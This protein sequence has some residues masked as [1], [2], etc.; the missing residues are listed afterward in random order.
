M[1]K[2]LVFSLLLLAVGSSKAQEVIDMDTDVLFRKNHSDWI[3]TP[4]DSGFAILTSADTAD[5]FS[6]SAFPTYKGGGDIYVIAR[7]AKMLGD[8]VNAKLQLGLY[9]GEGVSR[10]DGLTGYEWID[11]GTF[12]AVGEQEFVLKDLTAVSDK[13]FSKYMFRWIETGDQKNDYVQWVH[14]YKAGGR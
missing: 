14:H 4:A 12:N 5:T 2:L 11:L 7:V 6:S 3:S 10:S 1:Q 8:S 13:P 9:R